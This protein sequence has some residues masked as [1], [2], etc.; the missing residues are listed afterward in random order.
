VA[1]VIADGF[2][3]KDIQDELRNRRARA[4]KVNVAVA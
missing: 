1:E 4:V 3:G 2:K